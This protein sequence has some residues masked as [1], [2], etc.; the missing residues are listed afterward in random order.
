MMII[1]YEEYF[2]GNCNI[3]EGCSQQGDVQAGNG[4]NVNYYWQL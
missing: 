3:L 4:L 1:A 2:L